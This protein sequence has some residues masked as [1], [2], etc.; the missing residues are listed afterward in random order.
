MLADDDYRMMAFDIIYCAVVYNLYSGITI[1]KPAKKSSADQQRNAEVDG[2]IAKLEEATNDLNSALIEKSEIG[3]IAVVS[4][5][6]HHKM[7]GEGTVISQDD[8]IIIVNFATGE[9]KFALPMDF[10]AGF[11]TCE[12]KDIVELFILLDI[13]DKKI[14][15]LRSTVSSINTT[16]ERL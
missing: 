14:T 5:K 2:F 11:I 10:A 8:N 9:K 13:L 15:S 6:I 4:L 3:D 12:D 7:L 1:K 16:L